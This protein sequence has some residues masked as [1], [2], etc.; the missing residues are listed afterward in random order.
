[1]KKMYY[2]KPWRIKHCTHSNLKDNQTKDILYNQSIS[3]NHMTD[4]QVLKLDASITNKTNLMFG[5]FK[6]QINIIIQMGGIH[7]EG[8]HLHLICLMIPIR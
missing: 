1:M 5:N 4:H 2:L 3:Y 6:I 8:E 7:K